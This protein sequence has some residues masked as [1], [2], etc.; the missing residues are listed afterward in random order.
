MANY[1]YGGHLHQEDSVAY[2]NEW[3]PGSRP[4]NSG[5]YRCKNCGDEIAANKGNP[6]PPQNHHQHANLAPIVWQ[7]LVFAVQK[8]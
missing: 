4:P 1:K 5:I 8:N 6:L 2:D 7:L 3:A